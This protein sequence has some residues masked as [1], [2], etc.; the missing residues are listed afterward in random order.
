MCPCAYLCSL[1]FFFGF[2][3]PGSLFALSYSG[4]LVVVVLYI[5]YVFRCLYSN[6][7]KKKGCEIRLGVGGLG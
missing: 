6:Q 3:S 2:F 5:M 4:L 1:C 7:R